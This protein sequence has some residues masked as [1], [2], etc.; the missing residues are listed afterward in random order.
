MPD[1]KKIGLLALG[2]ERW[3]GGIQYMMNLINAINS[4]GEPGMQIHLFKQAA[5]KF[6]QIEKFNGV[7]VKVL[8]TN[9][10][11][12]PFTFSNRVKWFV[13][14]RVSG[15]VNPRME[16]FFLEHEYD[17]IYPGVFSKNRDKLNSASWIADFQS[18][19]YPDG[20]DTS[21]NRNA[22][23]Y[24]EDIAKASSK[25]VL[26]SK[27]CETDCHEFFP[28]TRGKTHVMPFAVFIDKEVLEFD[29]FDKIRLDYSLPERFLMVA[30][31]F[32]P[33]KDHAT[34]FEALGIL[35]KEGII[36]NLVCTG[37]ILDYR[38]LG[39][40]NEILQMLTKNRI[41]SQ[42]HM[43]GLIPRLHQLLLFRL[44]TAIVQP[45]LN[46]GWSTS[47]EEAKALGK[48][49]ILSDIP[50]HKEQL[51]GNP[52]FFRAQD[53]MDLAEKIRVI[54][55]REEAT[56]FPD[57]RVEKS[58]YHSYQDQVSRFGKKFIEI[59]SL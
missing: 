38:N 44:A 24:L 14:R 28:F 26:S 55:S 50:V 33:T 25:I 3:Q 13:Q 21:F 4:I 40:G 6:D 54:W 51:P 27:F 48:F 42:V 2:D 8:D 36:V 43:L 23:K 35:K 31:I 39:F 19:R 15:H 32:A 16:Q 46:E 17:F 52:D 29:E 47:V 7:D 49:L 57:K 20:A 45:S 12:K 10:V 1:I 5:Q 11:F 41:R 59:G 34:L 22:R 53:A 18:Y 56:E 9:K 37:N 30:N 58:A